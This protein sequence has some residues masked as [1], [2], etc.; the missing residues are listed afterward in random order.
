MIGRSDFYVRESTP[1]FNSGNEIDEF[2]KYGYDGFD[3]FLSTSPTATDIWLFKNNKHF[4]FFKPIEEIKEC[5]IL[6][7]AQIQN[8]IN[9]APTQD[10]LRQI[11]VPIG[12]LNTGDYVYYNNRFWLVN[13]MV[14]NNKLFETSLMVC[15]NYLLKWKDDY[16]GKIKGCWAIIE[17]GTKYSSGEE[18]N[19][20]KIKLIN[21]RMNIEV[22]YNIDTAKLDNDK[23]LY[24]SKDS[25][26]PR[27]Y[28][29]TKPDNI[30]KSYG[31]V[32]GTIQYV[33]SSTEY[34]PLK[35]NAKKGVA[36]YYVETNRSNIYILNIEDNLL[37][38]GVSDDFALDVKI[39]EGG[40]TITPVGL[41]FKSSNENIAIVDDDGVVQGVSVGECVITV[42]LNNVEK[43]I[44]LVVSDSK[45]KDQATIVDP[46]NTYS[47]GI[48]SEK[49]LIL[50]LYDNNGNRISI[51][52]TI[53]WSIEGVKGVSIKH[54]VEDY[55]VIDIGRDY[56]LVGKTFKVY[57][58][59]ET[60]NITTVT[61][62]KIIGGA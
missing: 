26:A 61:E 46:L 55:V 9:D 47:A 36:D 34:N 37:N 6:M 60:L 23:R 52:D 62:I 40:K 20:E 42:S 41:I 5:A 18:S 2:Y 38:I 35:D 11:V 12:T 3:E 24:I 51:P 28:K 22:P 57:A 27:V 49:E 48:Y 44:S 53:E 14:D 8:K 54:K 32:D 25:V 15:C 43:D 39:V 16:D 13:E 4:D 30:S 45:I 10:S 1:L 19:W 7:K 59:I 56:N 33:A 21:V 31:E 58:H 50:H 29:I 17:D